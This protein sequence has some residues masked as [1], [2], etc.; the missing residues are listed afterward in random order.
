MV[1]APY[2][3]SYGDMQKKGVPFWRARLSMILKIK[4]F[5]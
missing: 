1:K 3:I 5:S 2:A 4:L